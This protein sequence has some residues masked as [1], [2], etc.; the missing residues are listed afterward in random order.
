[1]KIKSIII[2]SLFAVLAVL[3]PAPSEA[4]S[5][6][7]PIPGPRFGTDSITCV[8]NL[9]LYREFFRQWRQ[10]GNEGKIIEDAINPWRWVFLNCPKA[11]KNIYLDGVAIVEYL[12]EKEKDPS[13]RNK[14]IDTLMMVY[15][16]RIRAFGEEGFVLGRKGVNLANYR[17]ENTQELFQ[18]F[19]RSVELMGNSTEPAVIVQYF[20]TAERM[21]REGTLDL[22]QFFN[23]YS[24]LIAIV[25]AG[26]E[27]GE[28]ITTME[29]V[30]GFLVQT[31]EPHAGCNDLVRIFSKKVEQSPDDIEL[32]HNIIRLFD[33]RGCTDDPFYLSVTIKAYKLDPSAESAFGIAKMYFRNKEYSKAIEFLDKVNELKDSNDRADG[34]L[35]LANSLKNTNDFPKARDAARN[36]IKARPGEGHAYILIGDMYAESS[37]SCGTNELTTRAVFWAAV[38]Q[39]IT[40]RRVDPTVAELTD[41]RIAL[42]SKHFPNY[43]TI[44]FHGFRE[45]D[46]FLVECWINEST[47]VRA[48]R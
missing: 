15:D 9:S 16:Q 20:R 14:L 27:A 24:Q 26:I 39:Y 19:N 30:R 34:F 47:T 33:R 4:Q 12:I 44:F 10:A 13:R 25:D 18:I 42:F 32:L 21:V 22:D 46:T 48:A 45:G 28:N 5:S 2:A 35:L 36:A 41:A 31:L 43:E 37:E 1:M 6:F 8:V 29:N 7:E 40:A 17:P 38:D 3:L 23:I 11:S